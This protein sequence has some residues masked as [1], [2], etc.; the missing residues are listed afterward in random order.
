MIGPVGRADSLS[1]RLLYLSI[2]Q[3]A[4]VRSLP[5]SSMLPPKVET[6]IGRV[7]S[8]AD[9]N[10]AHCDLSRVCSAKFFLL[11]RVR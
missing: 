5:A 3:V 4:Q 8:A 9:I 2:S 7:V 1:G 11:F 6:G 10:T